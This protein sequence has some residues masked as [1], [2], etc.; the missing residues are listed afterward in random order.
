MDISVTTVADTASLQ[1]HGINGRF[2]LTTSGSPQLLWDEM[3]FISERSGVEICDL[4]PQCLYGD[5]QQNATYQLPP[6]SMHWL[7]PGN[8]DLCE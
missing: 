3:Y 6:K 1:K 7:S 4:T 8:H 5:L 2:I